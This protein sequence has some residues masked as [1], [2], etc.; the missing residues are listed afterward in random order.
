MNS[1][2]KWLSE[3]LTLIGK[4]LVVSDPLSCFDQSLPRLCSEESGAAAL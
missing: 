2:P 3:V 4:A 1:W